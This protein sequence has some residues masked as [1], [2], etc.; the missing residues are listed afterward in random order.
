MWRTH[1]LAAWAASVR[2]GEVC[3]A[4]AEG[5]YGY[6][7]DAFNDTAIAALIARK[8]RDAGKGLIVLCADMEAV[9]RVAEVGALERA[10]LDDIWRAGREPVTVIL[11]AREDVSALLTG[12]RG[13]I[14]VRVPQVAYV[15]DYVRAAGGV[16]VSTSLNASGAAPC[17]DGS[18]IPEDVVA[19]RAGVL[20]GAVSRIW[21]A[22]ASVWL[23]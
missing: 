22:A 11:R 15:V 5:V 23:R 17:V 16:V 4:P 3:A 1:E 8:Q 9:A 6:C 12:G 18:E 10:M 2:R 7:A 13:T 20:S 14:A 21:D 19:L